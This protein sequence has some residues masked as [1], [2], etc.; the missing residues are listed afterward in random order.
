MIVKVLSAVLL[1]R[2]TYRRCVVI[3]RCAVLLEAKHV[4]RMLRFF[5]SFK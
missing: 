4:P 1:R 2:F 5:S 3:K